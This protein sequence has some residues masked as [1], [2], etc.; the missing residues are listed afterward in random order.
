VDTKY[1]NAKAD[2]QHLVETYIPEGKQKK[3]E[4]HQDAFKDFDTK[5]KK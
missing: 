3:V 4:R 5:K 1:F 2:Q